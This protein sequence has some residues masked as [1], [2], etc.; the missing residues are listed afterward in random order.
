MRKIVFVGMV[1][2]LLAPLAA[3]AGDKA[4]LPEGQARVAIPVKGM[5][6]G[7]SCAKV[8]TAVAK[9]DGVVGVKA[10]YKKGVATVVYEKE[11]VDVKQIVEVINTKTSF[12]A[13]A[14]KTETS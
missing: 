13:K 5:D 2:L 1:L 7:K 8:E 12:K 4:E 6:C 3:L 11:K 10:D 14:P 9:L